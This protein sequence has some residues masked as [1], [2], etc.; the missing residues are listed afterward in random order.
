MSEVRDTDPDLVPV[1]HTPDEIDAEETARERLDEVDRANPWLGWL[2]GV[3]AVFVI[4]G[5]IIRACW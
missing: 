3:V 1:I 2:A 5:G 4:A